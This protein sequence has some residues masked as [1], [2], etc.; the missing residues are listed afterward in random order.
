[1]ITLQLKMLDEGM[2]APRYQ[3]E[4]DAAIDLSSRI[5]VVLAPGGRETIPTGLAAAIPIGMPLWCCREAVWR[6]GTASG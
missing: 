2:A 6:R 4:G 1:M 3:H 5:D